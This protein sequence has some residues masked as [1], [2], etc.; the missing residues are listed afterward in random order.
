MSN[1][2]RIHS[3]DAVVSLPLAPSGTGVD[4]LAVTEDDFFLL[5]VRRVVTLPNR[6]W[7]ATS[8]TQA[9]DMLVATPCAVAVLDYALVQAQLPATIARLKQQFPDLSFV[10][11]GDP[12]DESAAT[13]LLERGEIQG[14]VLKQHAARRLAAGL[15]AGINRHFELKTDTAPPVA[16][17]GWRRPPVLAGIVAGVLAVIGLITAVVWF[18][19]GNDQNVPPAASSAPATAPLAQAIPQ[20]SPAVERELQQA[21]EAFEATRYL[22]TAGKTD[23]AL[24]HYQAAL[25]LDPANGEAKEGID[26][27]C[28]IMLARTEL[29]LVQGNTRE[30]ADTLKLVRTIEPAHPRLAFL[31]TQITREVT[32]S[33][34]AKQE[35]ERVE[36]LNRKLAELSKARAAAAA[37]PA[38]PAV[39]PPAPTQPRNTA[40]ADRLLALGYE[41]LNQGKLLQPVD[42]SAR[43]Y[44]LK[45]KQFQPDHPSLNPALTALR[46]RLFA[47]AEQALNKSNP[48]LAQN[49]L[50]GARTVGAD[51]SRVQE[52]SA[53]ISK[54]SLQGQLLTTPETVQSSMIARQVSPNYPAKARRESVEGYVDLRFISTKEGDVRDVVVVGAQ[55]EGYFEEEA[56][57]AVKRWKLKPRK[58]DGET[59]EQLL[60]LR[61]R[62]KLD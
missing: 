42:D 28:E 32:R 37:A 27:I 11:A 26:R 41:R 12:G 52:L 49:L 40:E 29:A 56:I 20:T 30:A 39:K 31:E 47:D 7:H 45:L 23:G 46:D 13:P 22:S 54:A 25:A 53:K 50:E 43:D 2:A 5:A 62:F 61:L 16:A 34:T 8:E 38:A 19:T 15:E 4:V 51:G 35:A 18:A 14:F 21:R 1:V 48:N 58:I 9:A 44:L 17:S 24:E 57:R 36:E 55:P 10:V 33:A 60:S 6:I 3:P 59:Y